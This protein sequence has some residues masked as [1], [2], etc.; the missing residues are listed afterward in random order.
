[1]AWGDVLQATDALGGS[2]RYQY[3]GF[4]NLTLVTDPLNNVVSSVTYNVRGMKT[5]Q[6][7]LDL[8]TWR[9][10][11]N[12]LGEIVSQTD[13]KN[14]TTTFTY[15]KL[16]RP[17]TRLEPEG[18]TTWTWGSSPAA[19]NVGQLTSVSGPGYSEAYTYDAWARPA[20]QTIVADAAY[21]YA[22]AYNSEG[23]LDTLTYPVST[24]GY[25]LRLGYEYAR[26]QLVRI[27]DRNAPATVLWELNTQDAAGNVVHETLGASIGVV[28]GFSPLTGLI[29]YRQSGLDGSAALQNLAY[30]WDAAGN[31]VL[32]QDLNHGLTESFDYDALDRLGRSLRN[33]VPNLELRYD[34]IGDITWKSDVGPYRYDT[35]RRHAVITAGNNSFAYDANGNMTQRNGAG[36]SW[37]SY[38]LPATLHA[39]NGNQSQFSYA[40]DRSRWRQ[41]ANEA[42]TAETTL[43]L[44]GLMEKITAS[45]LS[46]YRHYIQSP[47]GTAAVYLRKSGG[48][49]AEATYY[50]MHDH[51]GSTDKVVNAAGVVTAVAESFDAFGKRRGSNWTGPPD[52]ADLA[53]IGQTTRDGFTGHEHLDN[54]ELINMNGRIYDPVVARF[55]SADPYVQA[56][57]NSQSLNRYAYVWNNPL[58][59]VDPSGFEGGSPADGGGRWLCWQ[60][61]CDEVLWW[62]NRGW[63]D[64]ASQV[65]SAAERDPCGQDGSA[66][67]CHQ[68]RGGM[69]A[70]SPDAHV[71]DTAGPAA[72]FSG[73]VST[74]GGAALDA[75]P[76]WYYSG[77]ASAALSNQDYLL[78][79]AFYGATIGD[80]F[81]LGNV[82]KAATSTRAAES[83]V[84]S[85]ALYYPPTHGF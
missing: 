70:A 54:L 45:G 7:D 22:F 84:R 41:I 85:L 59:L 56:P 14:Q 11:P 44:G 37:F 61:D 64:R 73:L 1:S 12:A 33:G 46:T 58:S 79:F 6:T 53:A 13:A 15:D 47:T 17:L 78:A 35:G 4:G 67:A 10:T 19:R 3:D 76:G 71:A 80:V 82:S 48:S 20:T 26:G 68:P 34:A 66:M 49:P 60:G 43:Y 27:R 31:L 72:T 50:V 16:S 18:Y 77:Q 65:V 62:L 8:G 21:Q 25:R 83:A 2:T 69:V 55:L 52:V 5:R 74:V 75:I 63:A 29:E 38:N 30:Q 81:S 9:F 28:T 36:V 32:R 40:P 23:L 57:L 24:N 39:A 42:G 51:L